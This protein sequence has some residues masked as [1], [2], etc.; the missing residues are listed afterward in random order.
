MP[1]FSP[2]ELTAPFA[3]GGEAAIDAALAQRLL[4][5]ALGS[6]GDSADLYF[7]FRVTADYS[8]QDEQVKSV[9]RGVTLGLGVRVLKGDATGYAYTEDLDWDR[10]AHAAR[11]AGR[12]SGIFLHV[13]TGRATN[14]C[15]SLPRAALRRTLR[16]L[17]PGRRFTSLHNLPLSVYYAP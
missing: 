7:E 14:G 15:V 4:S 13:D 8:L 3:P 17:R 12:G 11:I 16:W 10:M 1:T 6:G 2:P 9:G 5:I